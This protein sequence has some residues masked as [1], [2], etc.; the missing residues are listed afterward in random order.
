VIPIPQSGGSSFIFQIY[1]NHFLQGFN[2][3]FIGDRLQM[4]SAQVEITLVAALELRSHNPNSIGHV[5][6]F[7]FRGKGRLSANMPVSQEL[8]KNLDSLFGQMMV[9]SPAQLF[10]FW[11]H[12]RRSLRN[13]CWIGLCQDNT[14]SKYSGGS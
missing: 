9:Q 14:R 8:S 3:G 2:N 11:K 12:Y 7:W 5:P 6:R 4:I 13:L 1:S 10:R